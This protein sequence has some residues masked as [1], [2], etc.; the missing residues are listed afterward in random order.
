MRWFVEKVLSGEAGE[1]AGR[2]AG[3]GRERAK[4][5]CGFGN[6]PGAEDL[7]WVIAELE[8]P[9]TAGKGAH[10]LAFSLPRFSW[11]M[12]GEIVQIT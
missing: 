11:V 1:G 8:L 2:Q 12:S 7:A 10:E 9:G 5:R 4:R 6:V 3:L